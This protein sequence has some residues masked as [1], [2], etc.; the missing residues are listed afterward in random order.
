MQESTSKNK[1]KCGSYR[2]C[3]E[4]KVVFIEKNGYQIKECTQCNHRFL[5]IKNV[6]N[7][8][9]DVYTDDYFFE[10][11]E[12]Y[13]NY[14]EEKEILYRSGV[15]Y[16]RILSKYVSPGKLLDVGCA[17]GFI[18]QGFQDNRWQCKG[19]EPNNTMA[20][21][22]RTESG[23]DIVTGGLETFN[24]NEKFDVISMI[25]VIG[26]FYDLDKALLN[27]QD[28]LKTGGLVLV[29][30]WNM[31]STIAKLMG[32]NWHEYSPPSVVN[33]FSDDTLIQLFEFYGFTL[34]KKGYPLK[35][36]NVK[37]AIS[38]FNSKTPNFIFK[39]QIFNGLTKV[40][41]GL[42]VIYPPVDVKWYLFRKTQD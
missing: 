12:G 26:H 13:P 34:V 21:Y 17:A 8:L 16:A 23:L 3:N 29:E 15:R 24:S 2:T 36:I 27:I 19:I 25:Q 33:W 1:K 39:K 32:K 28:L 5:E 42:P 10:G 38:L 4:N 22:G 40:F 31:K 41:G 37:H 11:K 7:H 35:R 6:E 20:A 30:S 14:L 18:M 9:T